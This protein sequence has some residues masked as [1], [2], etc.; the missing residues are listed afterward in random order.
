M[1][2]RVFLSETSGPIV[3]GIS[4]PVGSVRIQVI[5]NLTT[6]RV[7]LRTDDTTGPA[8]DAVN[9]ARSRQNGQAF[10]IE[11]P[12]MPG[13]VMTQSRRGNRIVQNFGT[14]YGSVTGMTVVNGR[15][16]SGGMDT[17]QTVSPIEATVCVPPRSS[18][19]VVSQ[20]ADA[21]VYGD[22]ERIEFRS[23]SGDLYADGARDLRANTTSGDI[24]AGRVTEQIT[25]QS[26]SGDIQVGSYDGRGASLDTTSGDITVQATNGAAGHVS[27]HSV[28]GD[29]RISGAGHLSVSANTVSGR[30]RNH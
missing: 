13:N 21:A 26:V 25:A 24:R 14:V 17:M 23:I 19:A 12:E 6:A 1:T 22:V 5:D 16:I 18:L 29:V 3:L 8:A 10:G 28:S 7:V 30:V 27:A 9:G 4:L 11:V 20:A 2:E 15:V